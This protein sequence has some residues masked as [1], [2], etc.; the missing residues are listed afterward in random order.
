MNVLSPSYLGS[1]KDF[2]KQ[3]YFELIYKKYSKICAILFAY[4]CNSKYMRSAVN[5]HVD[6]EFQ[7]SIDSDAISY[8]NL[9]TG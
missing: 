6:L 4:K 7:G 5:I 1:S 8:N 2:G 3:T 9:V